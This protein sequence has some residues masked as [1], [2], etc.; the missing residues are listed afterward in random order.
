MI[1]NEI[2]RCVPVCSVQLFLTYNGKQTERVLNWIIWTVFRMSNKK[3]SLFFLGLLLLLQH[4]FLS[5]KRFHPFFSL[6]SGVHGHQ[7]GERARDI[8]QFLSVPKQTRAKKKKNV[9]SNFIVCLRALDVVGGQMLVLLDLQPPVIGQWDACISCIKQVSW[10]WRAYG[11]QILSWNEYAKAKWNGREKKPELY[12]TNRQQR[13]RAQRTSNYFAHSA[14]GYRKNTFASSRTRHLSLS[15]R[16]FLS[17]ATARGLSTVL[18]LPGFFSLCCFLLLY[19]GPI[20]HA[21]SFARS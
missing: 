3:F 15:L 19:F 4:R 8:T 1:F 13:V 7:D 6:C 5:C 18:C 11:V 2:A 12:R 17:S 9:C 21:L 16:H 14:K 10:A 20:A